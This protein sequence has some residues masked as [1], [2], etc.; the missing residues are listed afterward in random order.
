MK[1]E[2]VTL[3]LIK[4]YWRNPRNNE[5]AVA[6]VAKSIEDYGYNS[7]IIVDK[8]YVVIAGHARL[9]ALQSLGWKKAAVVVADLPDEKAK[10]YRIADN[11]TGEIADWDFPELVEELRSLTDPSEF[12]IFFPELDLSKLLEQSAGGDYQI[13]KPEQIQSAAD[14]AA[15]R[16]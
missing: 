16:F 11:K 3:A 4:P 10:E 8:E 12:Q 14:N 6:A 1:T 9:K 13:V 2:E 15:A 7:P 5:Q